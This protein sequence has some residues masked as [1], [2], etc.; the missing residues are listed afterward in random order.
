MAQ[1]QVE[2]RLDSHEKEISKVRES[3]QLFEKHLE[4]MLIEKKENQ[5]VIMALMVGQSVS[6][7]HS[8]LQT[9]LS[10]PTNR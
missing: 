6:R 9:I 7:E 8:S 5:A 4:Q 2:D 1:K 10:V 3:L